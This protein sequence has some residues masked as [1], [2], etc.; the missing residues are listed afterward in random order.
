MH[1]M[2]ERAVLD[3]VQKQILRAVVTRPGPHWIQ[4]YAGTGKTII[5]TLAI[6]E[7]RRLHPKARVCFVTYTHALKDLVASGLGDDVEVFTVDAFTSQTGIYDWVFIDEVQDISEKH[8]S[9]IK[10]RGR[11]LVWAGDP[12]QS[13]YHGRV[14]ADRLPMVL[15]TKSMELVNIHRYSQKVFQVVSSIYDSTI[16]ED[17][18]VNV[19]D[20]VGVCLHKASSRS[21]ET[22]W[23]WGK[24]KTVTVIERPAAILFPTHDLAYEFARGV[25]SL[26]GLNAPPARVQ[27]G[28]TVDYSDFNEHFRRK[29]LPLQFLGS[30]NGSLPESDVRKLCYLMTYKSAKGLD[31]NSVF[32]P[33]LN[34]EISFEDGKPIQLSRD[35][36][37]RKFFFVALTR[38]RRDI[39]MSYHG[40]PHP[41]LAEMPQEVITKSGAGAAGRRF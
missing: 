35:E 13:L 15:G 19:E 5:V 25:C 29:R 21:A 2:V 11:L 24:A 26:E 8:I 7:I 6:A 40:K 4:G 31:F 37:Q 9:K 34:E 17:A 16:H 39:F 22:E 41:Y 38:S 28:K 14:N 3:D 18:L 10:S 23:V 1:W 30:N 36:W 33:R 20:D 27:Q 12:N 32:I